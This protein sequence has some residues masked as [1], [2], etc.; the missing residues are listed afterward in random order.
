M[1]FAKQISELM[2]E[3]GFEVVE[4]YSAQHVLS[5][6]NIGVNI[7]VRDINKPPP[8]AGPVYQ[9]FKQV[10]LEMPGIS[11]PEQVPEDDIFWILVGSRY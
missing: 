1:S 7:V 6:G 5:L 3:T 11:D 9:A 2:T 10:G 4:T 8:A